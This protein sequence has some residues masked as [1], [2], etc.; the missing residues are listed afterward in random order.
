MMNSLFPE[1][2]TEDGKVDSS[3]T[4]EDYIN[5]AI[6]LSTSYEI[7]SCGGHTEINVRLENGDSIKFTYQVKSEI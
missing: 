2:K 1:L 5:A 7:K 3:S 6:K 4:I